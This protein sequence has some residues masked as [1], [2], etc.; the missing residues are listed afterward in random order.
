MILSQGIKPDFSDR[1]VLIYQVL[2]L[3]Q[4]I[5]ILKSY[6]KDIVAVFKKGTNISGA[7][8]LPIMAAVKGSLGAQYCDT[9]VP[10]KIPP[11]PLNGPSTLLQCSIQIWRFAHKGV[12][13]IAVSRGKLVEA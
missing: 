8:S 10:T 9:K 1:M 5:S 7:I 13:H 2:Q 3:H 4:G 6:N 12:L 11:S